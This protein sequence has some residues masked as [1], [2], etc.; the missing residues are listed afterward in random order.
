MSNRSEFQDNPDI[1]QMNSQERLDY[2]KALTSSRDPKTGRFPKGHSG[3]YKGRPRTRTTVNDCL[4]LV[5]SKK[6]T[7]QID[8]KTVTIPLIQAI[9][10]KIVISA[11]ADNDTK[12]L[13]YI[14]KTFGSNIDI[15]KEYPA[16]KIKPIKE[17]PSVAI[18]K[19]AIYDRLDKERDLR[20]NYGDENNLIE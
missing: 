19:K 6:T 11:L 20:N 13:I 18:I 8:G 10:Y 2:L 1:N 5:F 17:D 9:C 3:N 4:S 14:L 12:T 15:S 16:P 7:M